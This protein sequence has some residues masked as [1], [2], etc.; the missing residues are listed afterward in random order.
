[1]KKKD[2]TRKNITKQEMR[3]GVTFHSDMLHF[4]TFAIFLLGFLPALALRGCGFMKFA[5]LTFGTF[6]I[7]GS[8]HFGVAENILANFVIFAA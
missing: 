4:C 7:L 2:P 1:M 6:A 5:T 8:A 3:T